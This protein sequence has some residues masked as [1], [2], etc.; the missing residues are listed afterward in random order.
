MPW[1]EGAAAVVFLAAFVLL[2]VGRFGKVPLP[3]GAVALVAGIITAWLFALSWRAID[4]QIIALLAGLMA[5]AG[6]A[7]EAGLFAGLRRHLVTVRAGLALWTS[8]LVMALAS[9]VM[10]NDAAVVVLVPFLLPTLRNIGLPPVPVVVLLAVASNV[11]SLLT[12]FGN[13]QN[14]ILARAGDLSLLDFLMVQA[15]WVA[16][17]MALLAIPSWLL[18]RHLVA[19]EVVP[20]PPAT[21]RGRPWLLLVVAAF[22]VAA[23]MQPAGLGLGVLA[24]AAALLAF[25]GLRPKIGR[26]ADR[27]VLRGLDWNVLAL[28][29]G[30]YL[31]TAGLPHWFPIEKAAPGQLDDPW[32]A[33]VATT[34]AS[35]VVGNVPATLMLLGLDPVWT[36]AHAPFLVTVTTLGGA[37][38]LTGSAASLLAAEQAKRFGVEVG[39][40]PFMRNALPWV[41]P[42][43]LLGAIVTWHSGIPG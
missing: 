16:L 26:A 27:A 37:L 36:A 24:L 12:P 10:L 2:A 43:L 33:L 3:R 29:A 30:M 13:P 42:V 18:A 21:P 14:A 1:R 39:F 11:G 8:L 6:L 31:L 34:L 9:G 15:P 32:S 4:L 23:A 38:L 40:V 19:V 20:T 28:F 7:E 17:G 22:V 35:N 41:L 5:L 25:A